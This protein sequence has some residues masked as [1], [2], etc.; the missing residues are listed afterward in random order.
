MSGMCARAAGEAVA[1]RGSPDRV[2]IVSSARGG[3]RDGA[4]AL[5]QPNQFL[6]PHEDRGVIN[7]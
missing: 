4:I 1:G 6:Q 2:T 7:C 5:P 3:A